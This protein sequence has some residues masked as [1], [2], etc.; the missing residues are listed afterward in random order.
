MSI[1]GYFGR[2][3]LHGESELLYSSGHNY[4]VD[5]NVDQ[6]D[7][8]A[9]EAHEKE[10]S[11]HS[12]RDV[13]ELCCQKEQ[14]KE[15]RLSGFAH[16]FN[17]RMLS[18]ANSIGPRS[19]TYLSLTGITVPEDCFRTCDNNVTRTKKQENRPSLWITPK[20]RNTAISG[21][22]TNID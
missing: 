2:D 9:N 21:T 6:L 1:Q 22:F 11:S 19:N 14:L 4:V 16:L 8:E 17:R 3:R 12:L 18:F 20:E 5:R 10:T 13:Q 15:P 7:K